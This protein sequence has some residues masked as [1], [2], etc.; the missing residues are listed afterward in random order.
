M[1]V[2][3]SVALP[4]KTDPRWAALVTGKSSKPLRLL[5]LK[6]LLTRT[7]MDSKKETSPAV[8]KKNV[9]ELYDY[10]TKTFGKNVQI[11]EDTATL[12]G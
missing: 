4:P 6:L 8:V 3:Q 1:A 10:F 5:A 2:A 9:D 11:I 7:S 12:F